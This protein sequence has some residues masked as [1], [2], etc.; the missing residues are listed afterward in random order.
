L[1]LSGIGPAKLLQEH[2]IKVVKDLPGVGENLQDHFQIRMVYQCPKPVTFNDLYHS[3][4]KKLGAGVQYI[5]KRSG[6]L[7]VGAGHVGLF[8]RTRPELESPDIQFHVIISSADKPG[9]GLHRFSGFTVSVCQLRPQS[10]GSIHIKSNDPRRHPAIQPN[11]LATRGDQ[12]TIID[13]LKLI[14]RISQSAS[15]Q[16]YISSEFLPGPQVSSD[17]ELLQFARDKGNTIFHPS[18]T[19]K[20]GSDAMAVV[21]EKLRVHGIEG[22]RVAD[23][24]IMPTVLSG[25]TNAGCI[26]IGEKAAVMMLSA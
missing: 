18:G 21:D 11:Y 10:R 12:Q 25:N 16:P 19:C 4:L 20:M 26:M 7:T 8:A 3:P 14:R 22:L 1:Q 2:D 17:Q 23:A 6:P 5:L 9:E 24:S 13:G 15:I